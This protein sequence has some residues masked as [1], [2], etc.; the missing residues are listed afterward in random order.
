MSIRNATASSN[1]IAIASALATGLLSG[2]CMQAAAE[3]ARPRSCTVAGMKPNDDSVFRSALHPSQRESGIRD[4]ACGVEDSRVLT[5]GD[6]RLRLTLGRLY[7]ER[8]GGPQLRPALI[9]MEKVGPDGAK[10]IARVFLG[11]DPLDGE[12]RFEPQARSIEGA[13]LI[14][15]SP[16]H[17]W[18]YRLD[19]DAVSPVLAFGWRDAIDG[20]FPADARSGE[21]LSIDLD[22][23]EGRIAVRSAGKDPGARLPSAYDE[24]RVVVAKLAWRNAQLAAE[25][26]GAMARLPGEERFLDDITAMDDNARKTLKNLPQGIEPCS[27]GAWSND[28]D[29]RGLNVRAAPD[30]KAKVLGIVPPPWKMPKDREVFGPEPVKAEFRII[31]QKDGWFLIEKIKA[32]GTPYGEAYPRQLPQPFKGRGWVNGRMV[33]AAYAHG[34]LPE[35][36]LYLSPHADA[37]FLDARDKSGN[38][39]SADGSPARILACSGWW[40]LIETDTG[41]R[42]WKRSLCSNQVTNCS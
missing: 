20:S 22:R 12:L 31:G 6:V 26:T 37:G 27:L 40:A 28:T 16:R 17:R 10:Q 14:R 7:E 25:S 8:V 5:V 15:L 30:A 34:G 32:P 1:R 41:Q 42:G 19:G 39:I 21:A 35:G 18:L 23:M 11:P 29:P 13:I 36:R 9:S 2:L 33:G 38:P 24:N 3:D 4:I